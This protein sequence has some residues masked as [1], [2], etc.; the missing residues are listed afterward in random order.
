MPSTTFQTV[1]LRKGRH[2]SPEEGAC[3]MELASMLAGEPF[4]DHP[5]SVCPVIGS[6]LRAYN[7]HIDDKRRQDLYTYAAKVVG[8]SGSQGLEAARREHLTAWLADLRARRCRSRLSRA[9]RALT[10]KPS[11]DSIGS[12]AMYE[13]MSHRGDLHRE[14]L[15]AIDDLVAVSAP[16]EG[17]PQATA[18]AAS[19]TGFGST[20]V[21]AS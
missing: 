5:A 14:V 10:P 15:A 3:V 2:G 1:R 9:L 13:I 19:K 8:T 21:S 4:S 17:A 12:R 11:F 16:Q 6:F 20:T 7:D 18:P